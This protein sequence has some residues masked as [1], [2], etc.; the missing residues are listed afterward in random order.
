MLG[1]QQSWRKTIAAMAF[2]MTAATAYANPDDHTQQT[3]RPE[4]ATL[5]KQATAVYLG[6]STFYSEITE[7]TTRS[8]ENGTA[9]STSKFV[10]ALDRSNARFCYHDITNPTGTAAVSNGKTFL[11][12]DSNRNQYIEKRA[13]T[14]FKGINIVDDITFEPIGG[15]LIALMLQGDAQADRDIRK[16]LSTATIDPVVNE[17]GRKLTP[18]HILLGATQEPYNVYFNDEHQI[19]RTSLKLKSADSSVDIEEQIGDAKLNKPVDPAVFL[20]TPPV[21]AI[22]VDHFMAPQRPGDAVLNTLRPQLAAFVAGQVPGT[23]TDVVALMKQASQAYSNMQTYSHTATFRVTGTVDGKKVDNSARFALAM[24]KPNKY[25]FKSLTRS[26]VAVVTDGTSLI[27][28]RASEYTKGP[29]PANISD[30]KLD[31]DDFD[32][33][34]GSYLVSV[35]LQDRAFKDPKILGILYKGTVHRGIT[36]DSKVWDALE[37]PMQGGLIFV[38]FFDPRTHLVVRAAAK[39]PDQDLILSETFED[40]TIDKPVPQ[41]AFT[42]ALPADAKLIKKSGK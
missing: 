34:A 8:A 33:V 31:Q 24:S 3:M 14:D 22:K 28:F 32:P 11:N 4:V 7:K 21:N 6:V 20:Y 10:L 30:I 25:A 17:N 16:A 15:Y 12:Y 38:L 2:F 42:Y 40:V 35:L 18:L 27:D 26:P 36:V 37:F 39:V 23:K 9:A 5:I 19:V 41:S 13:P 1:K 29:A